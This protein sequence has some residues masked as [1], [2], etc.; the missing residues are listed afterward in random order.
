MPLLHQLTMQGVEDHH[1]LF[2]TV[3][4]RDLVER[5]LQRLGEIF[6]ILK[7]YHSVKLQVLLVSNNHNRRFSTSTVPLWA[8]MDMVDE[9]AQPHHLIKATPVSDRINYCKSISPLYLFFNLERVFLLVQKEKTQISIKM[10]LSLMEDQNSST[11]LVVTNTNCTYEVRQ[12]PEGK[13]TGSDI[14]R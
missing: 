2:I 1:S 8:R 10:V 11:Q 9:K 6:S 12:L 3:P 5:M 4:G 14:Q 7:G 13:L